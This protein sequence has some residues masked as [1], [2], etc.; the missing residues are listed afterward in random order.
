[1]HGAGM[2]IV[3]LVC[4]LW[5]WYVYCGTG[6]CIVELVCV[7][8]NWYVYCGLVST[9]LYSHRWGQ[10]HCVVATVVKTPMTAVISDQCLFVHVNLITNYQPCCHLT[11]LGPWSLC[12]LLK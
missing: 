9:E 7:L 2:C 6:M 5:N 12:I 10:V 11:A 8:W 1:M 3:E 4:V